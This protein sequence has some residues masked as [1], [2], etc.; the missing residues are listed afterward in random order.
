MAERLL[1]TLLFLRVKQASIYPIRRVINNPPPIATLGRE[2]M[3]VTTVSCGSET[4]ELL[5]DYRDKHNY[6]NYDAA[7]RDLLDVEV[8]TE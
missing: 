6:P 7:L 4:R 8:S 3:D 5:A 1:T 2:R